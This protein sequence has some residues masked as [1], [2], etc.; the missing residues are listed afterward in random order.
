M[1]WPAL[2]AAA[3][4]AA[5]LAAA[6]GVDRLVA[7]A[8]E[9][10]LAAAAFALRG[11][12]LGAVPLPAADGV[13]VRQLAA[14]TALLP[15]GGGID[16]VPVVDAARF[17]ALACG[18]GAV[19]LLWPLV[20]RLGVGSAPAA[21]AVALVGVAPPVVALHA[22]VTGA[23][24]AAL[25]LGLAFALA[26][27]AGA[28]PLLAAV[29]ALLA[30][31][32]AP[33]AAACLLAFAAHLVAV[34][35][36][37]ARLAPGVRTAA[38]AVLALA[39]VGTAAAAAGDGP[40]AGVGGPAVGPGGTAVLLG[41][42]LA[43]LAAA[44]LRHRELRPLIS[45]AALLLAAAG[46]P[47][48]G[49]CTAL[50]LALPFVTVAGAVLVEAVA[51]ALPAPGRLAVA[52]V[53]PA[54]LA[55]ALVA[56]VLAPGAG[57]PPRPVDLA[58]WASTEL[59]P[60]T[61]LRADPLDR[62]ELLAGGVAPARLRDLDAPRA[63]GELVVVTER[64]PAGADPGRPAAPCPATA[65]LA[66]V[67]RGT[68]GAPTVVCPAAP[69]APATA[70]AERTGRAR[71]GGA[72]ARNPALDLAPG[73]AAALEAGVVDPRIDAPRLQGRGRLGGEV[74]RRVAGQR[75]A[76]AGPTR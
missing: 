26:V 2:V 15:A 60:D 30:V 56:L 8:G 34:R 65:V 50:L 41:V 61:V 1:A 62:A 47:G 72:L 38:V 32:S 74:Q 49:R 57:R 63:P 12:D 70:S 68:G 4:V 27:R 71:F 10:R 59:G 48:A 53:A 39:A 23:A 36:V 75:A 3:A 44:W 37:A 55:V 45:P 40:L 58:A 29:P 16:T 11:A 13:A 76:E 20:R 64:P 35:L 14:L 24:P 7:T 69:P 54:A 66:S 31:L 21:V 5:H 28:G 52:A 9:A 46:V 67:A 42:G 51:A 19:L 43:V 6:D 25:W 22:G 33:L 18:V 73:A 17:A